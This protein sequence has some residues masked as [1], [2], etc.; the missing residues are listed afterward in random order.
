MYIEKPKSSQQFWDG[1]RSESLLKVQKHN[2][3]EALNREDRVVEVG[4]E[5][6]EAGQECCDSWCD[7]RAEELQSREEE[8][9]TRSALDH[10]QGR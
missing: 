9:R 2:S 7:E 6:K 10:H 5:V 1:S 8:E 3:W 4:I